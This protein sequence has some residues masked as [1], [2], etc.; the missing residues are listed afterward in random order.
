MTQYVTVM[1]LWILSWN[2]L[3]FIIQ[4]SHGGRQFLVE[5]A[6]PTDV[7]VFSSAAGHREV[8]S[9]RGRTAGG[10][11]ALGRIAWLGNQAETKLAYVGWRSGLT[12]VKE[13]HGLAIAN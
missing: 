12:N 7:V 10:R 9:G 2:H 13:L 3:M 1:V 8:R 5:R 11:A 6:H 4:H